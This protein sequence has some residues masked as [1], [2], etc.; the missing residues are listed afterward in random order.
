[1]SGQAFQHL[2]CNIAQDALVATVTKQRLDSENLMDEFRSELFAAVDTHRSVHLVLD[3]QNVQ[4]LQTL[5]LKTLLDLRKKVTIQKGRMVLCGL[6]PVVHEVLRITGFI[7]IKD[8]SRNL[9]DV[10]ADVS[11]ALDRINAPSES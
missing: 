8:P 10:V 2:H 9:F 1:M 3:L 7:D 11:C 4:I 5:V 6:K